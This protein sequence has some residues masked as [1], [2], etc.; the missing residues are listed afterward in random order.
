MITGGALVGAGY[1]AGRDH[2]RGYSLYQLYKDD[3]EMMHLVAAQTGIALEPERYAIRDVLTGWQLGVKHGEEEAE[4]LRA[5]PGAVKLAAL[6]K[7]HGE[8]YV[9]GR[10]KALTAA[11]LHGGTKAGAL[12]ESLAE[13]IRDLFGKENATT[14]PQSV[15]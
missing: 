2:N 12:T 9:L 3:P 10:Q 15:A 1:L 13:R 8:S 4:G 5:P 11:G 6:I 7:M 14:S